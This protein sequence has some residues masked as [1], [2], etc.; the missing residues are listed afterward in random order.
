MHDRVQA[1]I[2]GSS[3]ILVPCCIFTHARVHL[4]SSAAWH[5]HRQ[6]SPP[7][8][9]AAT[10]REAPVSDI[11]A[12]LAMNS[13]HLN[14]PLIIPAALR[15][16]VAETGSMSCATDFAGLQAGLARSLA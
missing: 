4:L 7:G 11:P 8:A 5:M 9:S 16:N 15:W 10:G 14:A 3:I 13:A 2:S 1:F 12:K 6:Q